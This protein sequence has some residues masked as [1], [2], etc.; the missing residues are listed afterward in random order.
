MSKGLTNPSGYADK[1]RNFIVE[2]EIKSLLQKR[3][4]ED[5]HEP[6]TGYYSRVFL[7]LKKSGKWRLIL[8]L[9]YLNLYVSSPKFKQEHVRSVREGLRKGSWTYSIDLQDAFF[10]IPMQP[11]SRKLLRFSF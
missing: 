8:N 2:E 9:K 5:V 1:V 6:R 11:K 10:H 7:R 3:A 4:I